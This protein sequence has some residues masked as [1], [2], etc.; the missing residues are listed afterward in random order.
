M[1]GVGDGVTGQQRGELL[2]RARRPQPLQQAGHAVRVLEGDVGGRVTGQQRGGLLVRARP[3]Q[4]IQ[5]AGHAAGVVEGGVGDGVTGQQRG[6]LLA[7]ARLAHAV[8]QAGHAAGV[9]EGDVGGGA[10]GQR[11]GLLVRA[12]LA[13]CCSAGW[14]RRPGRRGRRG[15][16][17]HG[18]AARRPAPPGRSLP[19]GRS[20]LATLSGSSR[21]AWTAAQCAGRGSARRKAGG[22]QR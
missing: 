18:P 14:P 10:A 1:A 8:Q 4:N 20:S 11:G 3:L 17:G 19:A 7:R 6:G 22:W 13:A 15:R 16:P 12:R 9:V 5:Q 21:E 2:V